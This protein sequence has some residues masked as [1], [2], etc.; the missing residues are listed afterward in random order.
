LLW[1]DWAQRPLKE[2]T[3]NRV[4]D[5][6]D[7]GKNA[8]AEI[9]GRIGAEAEGHESRGFPIMSLWAFFNVLCWYVTHKAVSKIIAWIW[10]KG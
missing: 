3:Y 4:F 8:T 6:M 5:T 9:E 1:K 10:S 2:D 7:F